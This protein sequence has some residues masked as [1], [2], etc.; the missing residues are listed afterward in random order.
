KDEKNFE[1]RVKIVREIV[2]RET[3][4]VSHAGGNQFSDVKPLVDVMSGIEDCNGN[5]L[6]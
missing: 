5:P 1:K 3:V 6:G 4:E 2:E